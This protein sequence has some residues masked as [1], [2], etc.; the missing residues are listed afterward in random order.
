MSVFRY[1]EPHEPVARGPEGRACAGGAR[2]AASSHGVSWYVSWCVSWCVPWC[3]M[4]CH[5]VSW[6]SAASSHEER[7]ASPRS[8]GDGTRRA[9]LARWEAGPNGVPWPCVMLCHGMSW[10]VTAEGDGTRRAPLAR[11]EAGPKEGPADR[12][13]GGRAPPP[14]APPRLGV[15][16][17]DV[18]TECPTEGTRRRTRCEHGVAVFT[19][20]RRADATAP[21]RDMC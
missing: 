18:T 3:V 17:G 14:R 10:C 12:G 4:V 5:G 1:L 19:R 9:P 7:R 2:A 16:R 8:E 13:G 15:A 20:R 6:R 21:S 11:W